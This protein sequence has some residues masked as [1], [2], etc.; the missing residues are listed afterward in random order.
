M[1][2]Q[3]RCGLGCGNWLP[4]RDQPRNL[5]LKPPPQA[6][7]H[8]QPTDVPLRGGFTLPT[9]SGKD[10]LVVDYA[11]KWGADTIRDSD[12]TELSESLLELGLDI[13]S[14]VCITRADQ[15]FVRAHPEFLIRKFFKSDPVTAAAATVELN[16][17]AGFSPQKYRIDTDNDP[18]TYWDV[19]DRTTGERVAAEKW[20]FNA[21]TGMVT[22]Q[23][24]IPWHQYTVNFLVAQIWDST[25]MHNHLTNGWTCDPIMSV[26]PAHP[27]CREHLLKWFD[28]WLETHPRTKVVRLTTLCYHFPI[29][30]AED[31]HTRYFD[32]QGYADT[33]SIPALQEFER[34]HGYRLS[35][36]DFVD[37]GYYIGNSHRIPTA[38]QLAWMN[39]IHRFIIGF[40]RELTDRIHAAGKK[41]AIFWGDHWIGVEPYLPSFAEMGIDIHINACEGGVVLRRCGEA[42]GTQEKELRFYPYLFP[43]TFNHDG[44]QP[45]RDSRL[46]W[47]NVRRALVRVPVDRI[48]YGGY[49]SL[50]AEFPEFVEQV[51]EVAREFRTILAVTGKTRSERIP[52]KVG[53]LS[54]WGSRRAWIPFEGKDQK[55][56]VS[57]SDNMFLLARSYLLE[58]LAGLPVDVVF[59]SFDDILHDGIP[60][61]IGVL[62]NDGDAGTAHSGGSHWGN[63]DLVALVRRF[64]HEGGGFVGVR[65]PTACPAQGRVF[66][67]SDL[68][69]VDQVSGETANLRP[70]ADWAAN[71]HH[72]ILA[73]PAIIPS[74]G[75][76]V[77][78]VAPV[79]PDTQ[80]LAT[81]PGGHVLASARACGKGRAVYLAG[82]PA[83]PTN[84]A[85]LL[86]VLA[87]AAGREDAL[88]FWN[89]SN[90][91]TECAWYPEVGKLIVFNNSPEPQATTVRCGN[92]ES[93]QVSLAP[94]ESQWFE[95]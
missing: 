8:F 70:V 13:Y 61:D 45:L 62:I 24:V 23:D 49:L 71:K 5:H 53:I 20:D 28:H 79:L 25:S 48:G 60:A 80:V 40:G 17:M 55:F 67:L 91:H 39:H 85:L 92:G 9:E 50:A 65:E 44:G 58:C 78:Y 90:P 30:A 42:P 3:E 73:D 69:G 31:G 75:T 64:V 21:A 95:P 86:R 74:F 34:I 37:Q 68:L 88:D 89:C 76:E 1:G 59:L 16:P 38:R 43:D 27:A 57:Y 54:A 10:D 6:L 7:K 26:D 4:I 35:S 14:T 83:T 82:L 18:K 36:E 84:P 46:F 47:A 12:G 41:A 11:A 66:Q 87:W 52:V 33:V 72:F 77:S 94:Y 2:K 56:P 93:L 22:V 63:P 15:E 32:G 29:D 81:G 51:A 19:F